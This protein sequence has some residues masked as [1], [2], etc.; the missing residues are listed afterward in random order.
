MKKVQEKPIFQQIRQQAK[1]REGKPVTREDIATLSGLTPGE[2]YIVDIG[3]WSSEDNI[4]T[5]LR[6]FN[7]LT[8]QHLAIRDI[9]YRQAV[10]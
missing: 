5:V 1:T 7:I 3:G 10:R 4:Q 2:V 6:I 9:R 8:G